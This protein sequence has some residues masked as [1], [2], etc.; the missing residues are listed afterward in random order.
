MYKHIFLDFDGVIVDSTELKHNAFTFLAEEEKKGMGIVLDSLLRT[1]LIGS[2]RNVV[3]KW[4]SDNC[5]PNKTIDELSFKFANL[6][7]GK[8]L[9]LSLVEGF[10]EFIKNIKYKNGINLSIVSNAPKNDIVSY[11]NLY[12]ILNEFSDIIGFE[13]GVT[14]AD[15]IFR[16]MQ[17]M[18]LSSSQ[19]LFIG[20]TPS[21]YLASKKCNISFIKIE[22][23]LGNIC[24]WEDNIE[25]CKNF[26]EINK[27]FL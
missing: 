1:K 18:N 6:I 9:N 23:F 10:K 21:D 25:T 11:L 7:D 26:L 4:I 16:L 22:S 12:S 27:H 15:R 3:C 2:E 20:D 13:E 5:N 24:L 14:K 17:K 19:C 8:I